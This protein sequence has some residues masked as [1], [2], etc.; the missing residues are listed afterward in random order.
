MC[1][2][3]VLAKKKTD[4]VVQNNQPSNHDMLHLHVTIWKDEAFS[5]Q[6]ADGCDACPPR[7]T[8]NGVMILNMINLECDNYFC[9]ANYV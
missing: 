4:Y 7:E 2:K 8:D 1:K 3:S 9:F 5:R 6:L